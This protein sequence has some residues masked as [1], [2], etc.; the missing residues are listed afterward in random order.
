MRYYLDTEFDG[1]DGPLVS[2]ALV[3]DDAESFYYDARLG[4]VRDGWVRLNVIPLVSSVPSH[5]E[6]RDDSWESLGSQ[7]ADFFSDDPDPTIVTDWPDDIKYMCQAVITGPGQMITV[8]SLKFEMHR[9]DAY[10]T[11]LPGAIQ[12]NAWWD[13]MALRHLFRSAEQ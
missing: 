10:P 4:Q 5:I 1:L 11:N 8:P 12:H 7:L 2:L 13:A 6:I 9:V 3:R